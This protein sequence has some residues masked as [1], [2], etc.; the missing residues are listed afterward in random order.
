MGLIYLGSWER[1]IRRLTPT[2]VLAS[3]LSQLLEQSRPTIDWLDFSMER[4]DLRESR[5][6]ILTEMLALLGRTDPNHALMRNIS[7]IPDP[8]ASA[9]PHLLPLSGS[10]SRDLTIHQ[11]PNT[12]STVL[13]GRNPSLI[14]CDGLSE[15]DGV[16]Q[17]DILA[18]LLRLVE[19]GFHLLVTSRPEHLDKLPPEFRLAESIFLAENTFTTLSIYVISRM[20]DDRR[21]R[22]HADD[23]I[24]RRILDIVTTSSPSEDRV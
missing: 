19:K 20:M 21:F 8:D 1:V 17:S 12:S 3:L 2:M 23:N 18:P 5:V 4:S 16:E 22:R 13:T 6:E 9:N 10:P 14:I 24:R 15:L 11:D 7:S